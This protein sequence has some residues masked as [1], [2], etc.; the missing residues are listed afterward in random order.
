MAITTGRAE[1]KVNGEESWPNARS[2]PS[3]HFAAYYPN[4]RVLRLHDPAGAVVAET[5]VGD[6]VR[7]FDLQLAPNGEAVVLFSSYNNGNPGWPWKRWAT[8]AM[9]GTVAPAPPP[10]GTGNAAIVAQIEALLKQI[11]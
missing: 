11:V 8:G 7:D 2:L 4:S 6:G 3:G 9:L 5:G 10:S 1:N